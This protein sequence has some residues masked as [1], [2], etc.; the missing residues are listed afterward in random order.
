MESYASGRYVSVGNEARDYSRQHTGDVHVTGNVYQCTHMRVSL[1][2]GLIIRRTRAI[3]RSLF[4]ARIHG[5]VS[6]LRTFTEQKN[7]KDLI[8]AAKSGMLNRVEH[9]PKQKPVNVVSS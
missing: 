3:E 6:P 5:S 8:L 9:L 2:T 1:I 7:S 4:D